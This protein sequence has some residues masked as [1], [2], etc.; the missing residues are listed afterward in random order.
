MIVQF[1]IKTLKTSLDAFQI[2]KFVSKGEDYI[3]LDSSK[4]QLAY[5]R[6]SII[7]A[8]PFLTVKYKDNC[9]Y[10]KIDGGSFS[11]SDTNQNIFN[12]LKKKLKKYKIKNPTDLPFIGGA[13]G[14][15]SY[16]FGCQHK[17]IKMPLD[18]VAVIPGAYFVFYDNGIIIDHSTNEV[19]ITGLGILQDAEK[20][21]D[22]LIKQ[23]TNANQIWEKQKTYKEQFEKNQKTSKEQAKKNRENFHIPFFKSSFSE[24]DYKKAV[25][26][27]QNYI[28]KGDIYLANMTHT[29]SSLFQNDPQATYEKLRKVNPAP[30]SAYLPLED[31]HVLCSSPERFLQVQNGKVETRPIK[32]TIP[33]GQTLKEDENNRHILENSQ[34]D[35]EELATIVNLEQ[36][37]L[38]KVCKPKTVKVSKLFKVEAFAT[39]FHL[40]STITGILD[41]NHTPV[42]CIEAMFPGGSITGAPKTRAMEIIS[43]LENNKRNLYTGI[44]GYFGFDGDADFNVVIRSVLIKDNYAHIGVGG[45]ITYQ[46]N[47]KCEYDETIAKAIALFH[48]L[49]ADYSV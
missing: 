40:V 3:F 18:Q 20:S 36:D 45:G 43:K 42:D 46:S 7:G 41:N 23:I 1:H 35:R 8:N 16:D 2:Y 14:Y 48:S 17:H 11:P 19:S 38:K 5:G 4:R 32:G 44:I 30:F 27:M 9:I 26:K 21:V 25:K 28:N 24:K 10:E 15:F 49:G 34:K 47:A 6:Y 22:A 29:F 12:Y 31:F 13:M 39:V 37:N 33:R